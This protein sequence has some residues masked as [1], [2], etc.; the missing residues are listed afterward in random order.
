MCVCVC[1]CC[2]L[3]DA[4]RKKFAKCEHIDIDWGVDDED[5]EIYQIPTTASQPQPSPKS[6]EGGIR[7]SDTTGN[8]AGTY[9]CL[10]FG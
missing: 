7:R 9:S 10:L 2:Q 6:P 4:E 8:I 3:N 5:E 1:V